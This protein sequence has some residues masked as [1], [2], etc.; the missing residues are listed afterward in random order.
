MVISS[1]SGQQNRVQEIK[2][3]GMI[4]HLYSTVITRVV[5]PAYQTEIS[6]NCWSFVIHFKFYL[7]KKVNRHFYIKKIK[8]WNVHIFFFPDTLFILIVCIHWINIQFQHYKDFHEQL[9][10]VKVTCGFS[11]ASSRR[12]RLLVW[13]RFLVVSKTC[14]KSGNSNSFKSQKFLLKCSSEQF[15]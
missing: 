12:F 13:Q 15:S 10:K 7:S 9:L 1:P 3:N 5:M 11:K 6:Q 14:L 2:Q 8:C 4:V